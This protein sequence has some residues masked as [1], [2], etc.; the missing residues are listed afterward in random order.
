MLPTQK[1]EELISI[2]YVSAII[3]H[4]GYSPNTVTYDYGIDL[5]IHRIGVRGA[6]RVDLGVMLTLQ[7]KASINWEADA[8]H[9]VFDLDAEAYNNLVYRRENAATP[10][11]LI[12]CCLPRDS[13]EWLKVCEDEL[14]IKKCCYYYFVDGIETKNTGSKRIR[15]PRNQLLT[16]QSIH[17]LQKN[18]YEGKL[19]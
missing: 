17:D 16:P 4:A 2:S 14:V 5:M 11:A 15:I 8:D 10:C 1:I 19:V 3:A 12:L 18:I 6:K 13:S 7:L 9:I